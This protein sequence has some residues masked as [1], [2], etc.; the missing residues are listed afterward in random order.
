MER[1]LWGR[2]TDLF[3][4]ALGQEPAERL[5]FLE[6]ECAGDDGLLRQVSALLLQFEKS[7]D[8]LEKPIFVPTH[9]LPIGDVIGD[10]YRIE[11]LVGRG[12]MGEVYRAHDQLLDETVALKTLRRNLGDDEDF[13]RR[14]RREVQLARKVTHPSVCRVFD[15][16]VHGANGARQVNFF[17]MQFLDGETLAAR[18]RRDGPLPRDE[19][20]ARASEMASGLDAA[21]AA[22]IVHRDFKSANVMLCGEH[23]VIMDFGLAR[24]TV[25]DGARHAGASITVGAQVAGTIAYMS[26]EQLSGGTVTTASDIYSFGVV[27]FEMATGRLPFHDQHIIRSAMQRAS[28]DALD[29]RSLAPDVDPTWAAAIA[30]CLRVDSAKRFPSAGA[31]TAELNRK[32]WRPPMVY[33]N[34][35]QW[36]KATLA[37]AASA[38]SVA[39]IPAAFRYYSQDVTL[40]DGAEVLLGAI[41]NSTGDARLDGITELFRNQLAQSVRVNLIGDDRLS[42]ALVQMGESADTTDPAALREA[43]WR[44]NAALSVFGNVSRIGPDYALN[45]QLETR[46]SQP[47]NPRSKT[48]HSFSASD[49]DA[50]MRAVRDASVWARE[51]IGE[52]AASIASFDRLPENA[53]TPS[54]EALTLYARGQHFFMRQDFESAILQFESALRVDPKFTLAALRRADLLMSQGRQTEGLEQW[55]AAITLLGE[56]PVTRAEELNARGMFAQDSGDITAADRYFRTWALEYP[57]DWRAPFYRVVP[58]IL[59][60]RAAQALEVLRPL[61]ASVPEYGDVYALM[62]S[63]RRHSRADH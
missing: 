43:A 40:P 2:I 59:N 32:T 61:L 19:A 25:V 33:W 45:V 54:W 46:G 39:L 60:G 50:L 47:D 20:L 18:I 13:S 52:S 6:Q 56:R 48:L 41:A 4:A 29:I 42:A 30:R 31:V 5:L 34:R 26:P 21:H 55:R 58:L 44:L 23:A 1:E 37:L 11:A 35:R 12:G 8:F 10:R 7:A 49:P 51:A 16:G 63:C 17:A 24:A 9:A 14:F 3:D 38:G 36:T 53:T 22:G 28:E 62:I 27:L 15:V 57:R